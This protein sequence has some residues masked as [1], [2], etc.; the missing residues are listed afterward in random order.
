MT[1]ETQ[2]QATPKQRRDVLSRLKKLFPEVGSTCT[3]ESMIA[4][5]ENK[6]EA[7]RVLSQYGTPAQSTKHWMNLT[8][9]PGDVP[10][11]RRDEPTE[12]QRAEE[13]FWIAQTQPMGRPTVPKMPKGLV[14]F[15]RLPDG[16]FR[17]VEVEPEI[18]IKLKEFAD[19][20]R[21]VEQAAAA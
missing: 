17:P 11:Y 7:R 19:A 4:V 3:V 14:V 12:A 6:S 13:A 8:F 21:A 1:E 5:F 20:K 16:N 10:K 9:I 18:A 2:P 15:E